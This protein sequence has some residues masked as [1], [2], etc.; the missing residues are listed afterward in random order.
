[1]RCD[2]QA[3]QAG[4]GQLQRPSACIGD[5]GEKAH[6]LLSYVCRRQLGNGRCVTA[7]V[8]H[9]ISQMR[10]WQQRGKALMAS[11][12]EQLAESDT[13]EQ[14]CDSVICSLLQSA[15]WGCSHS[16]I[17]GQQQHPIGSSDRQAK[18]MH[19]PQNKTITKRIRVTWVLSVTSPM[20]PQLGAVTLQHMCIS[21]AA[22]MTRT[23]WAQYSTPAA[24]ILWCNHTVNC[25]SGKDSS[26]LP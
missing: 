18:A 11:M 1:M 25:L 26:V 21:N 9:T 24:S 8:L 7:S 2:F 17:D 23:C 20:L 3:S 4:L 12:R 5:A 14:Q 6:R 16:S 15:G 19:T 22:G 10:N 13:I